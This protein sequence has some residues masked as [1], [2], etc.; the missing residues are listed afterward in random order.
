MITNSPI[1]VT[2][3][4]ENDEMTAFLLFGRVSSPV[5]QHDQEESGLGRKGHNMHPSL[6]LL[7]FLLLTLT[8]LASGNVEK[9]IFIAPPRIKIPAE[10][11]AG[12]DDLGLPRL[13]PAPEDAAIRTRLNSSFP[14]S[15]APGG[16]ES[17]FYLERLVPGV[18]YEVRICWLATVC[19]TTAMEFHFVIFTGTYA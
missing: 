4:P 19:C 7:L 12:V 17:W 5:L 1:Y 8:S 14:T 11:P 2:W 9:T 15:D 13:S 16:A 3:R 6:C 10:Q 18:R